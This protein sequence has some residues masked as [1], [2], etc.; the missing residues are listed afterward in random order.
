MLMCHLAEFNA[1]KVFRYVDDYLILF[2]DSNDSFQ[3]DVTQAL[4]VFQRLFEPLVLT[5]ELPTNDTIRF[6]DLSITC[7]RDHICWTYDPRGKKSV[8]PFNS[9]HSKLVKR[10]IINLCLTNALQKSCPHT[11]ERSFYQQTA[12]LKESGYPE[13]IIISVA[14]RIYREVKSKS[15][16]SMKASAES[17]QKRNLVVVPYL[18]SISHNLKR[19]GKKVKLRVLFSAPEKLSKLCKLTQTC[20]TPRVQC[21]KKHRSP[22]VP[23]TKGVVYQIPLSCGK[24]Y[25]GQ[26]GRCL[27]DRLRE[28]NNNYD[29]LR[30]RNIREGNL[31]VHCSEC[32]KCI[33]RFQDTT[34]LGRS[35]DQTTREIIE[36]K[37]I[38]QKG[39][40][41]VSAVS[42]V[43]LDK[44]LGFLQAAGAHL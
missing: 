36:A 24:V 4:L 11:M 44:E 31:A 43:L 38:Q 41:C 42:L 1:V 2:D 12:R 37:A 14:E 26:S 18:H 23:C 7:T 20:G 29:N 32:N 35:S 15:K 27:N 8:L 34:I 16:G 25:I 22:F 13:Q 39:D 3:A 33:P 30:K 28:H 5:H 21:S 10:S 6:L 9:A 19:I 17:Q 40:M